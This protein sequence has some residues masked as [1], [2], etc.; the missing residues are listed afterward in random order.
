[1]KQ[2]R[3]APAHRQRGLAMIAII[4]LVVLM[5]AYL[6]AN[7]LA[8]TQ[9]EVAVER[10]ALTQKA[11]LEAKRALIAWA[12]SDALQRG[13]DS[14]KRYQPGGLPCPDTNNDGSAEGSCSSASTRLGRL[15]WKTLGID[16]LRDASGERLWY[17]VSSNY[18]K[19]TTST[20]INSDTAA[21][22]TVTGASP[23]SGVVAVVI[24]P[25]PA[26][27]YDSSGQGAAQN[28]DRDPSSSTALN[29]AS[30]YLEGANAGT[31]DDVFTVSTL[32]SSVFND[33]L[34]IITKAELFDVVEPAVAAA[35]RSNGL[36][37]GGTTYKSIRDFINDYV[38]DWGKYPFPAAFTNPS[39]SDY[40]GTVGQQYG[41][42]PLT[43]ASGFVAWGSPTSTTVLNTLGV[44]TLAAPSCATSTTTRIECTFLYVNIVTDATGPVLDLSLSI[45][46]AGRAFVSKTS[47]L[48][49]SIERF[50]SSSWQ[51]DTLQPKS[52]GCHASIM[53][54]SSETYCVQATGALD[55]SGNGTEALRLQLQKRTSSTTGCAIG[56]LMRLRITLSYPEIV[57]PAS[58]S[59][60]YWFI[61]NEWYKHVQYAVSPAYLPGGTAP[62]AAFSPAATNG[63][64]R[65]DG[66]FGYAVPISADLGASSTTLSAASGANAPAAPFRARIDDEIVLV[67][68]TGASP[69][70]TWTVSRAQEGT[71][72]ATHS[73]GATIKTAVGNG[74]AL[75]VLAG[76]SVNGN[77]RP[78][79]A[80]T[81]YFE[82]ENATPADRIH[83]TRLGAART[84]NDRAILL[85]P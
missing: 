35:I 68:S 1:V 19:T 15:P 42:L 66:S 62:C 41:L 69:W 76:R 53:P 43:S 50:Y 14:S 10:E 27:Q 33:R 52:S 34:R 78:S 46:N 70:T 55:A 16:D 18:R 23:A 83:E 24:A 28:Q 2:S 57:S 64:L 17:A 59:E 84:I 4:T 11:L 81:D 8:R 65:V 6:I 49:I 26:L 36:F 12:A 54:A 85:A 71:A 63:C 51:S 77:A 22:I 75:L 45:T 7:G 32:A 31:N 79:A 20:I 67:T 47:S 74:W 72:A 39:T 82:G 40:K 9:A 56:C 29:N 80:L 44:G 58:T 3:A 30:N 73:S 48:D 13:T 38:S 25:G 61:H 5:S 37:G 21:Q 60:A